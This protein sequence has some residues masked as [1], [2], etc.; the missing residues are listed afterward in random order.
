MLV[1]SNVDVLVENSQA[2]SQENFNRAPNVAFKSGSSIDRPFTG[3]A[4]S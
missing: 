3:R 1:H 4:I 2:S